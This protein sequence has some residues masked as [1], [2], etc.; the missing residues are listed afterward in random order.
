MQP[1]TGNI[2]KGQGSRPI[3]GLIIFATG[4]II[5]H[6]YRIIGEFLYNLVL[7]LWVGGIAIFT[8]VATP[9]IFRGYARDMAAQ[10]VGKLFDVYFHYNMGLSILALILF[11]AVM[12]SGEMEGYR[13]SLILLIFAILINAYVVLK[14]HPEIKSVKQQVTS[15]ETAPKDSGPRKRFGKLHAVSMAMNLLLLADGVTLLYISTKK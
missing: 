14:L 13:V 8:F 11:L 5:K 12:S 4:L 3:Y 10:I 9:A 2:L 15:F 6:M 1:G 7:A